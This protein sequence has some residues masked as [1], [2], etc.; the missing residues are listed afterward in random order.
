MEH[1]FTNSHLREHLHLALKNV[2]TVQ[3]ENEAD[4]SEKRRRKKKSSK[5]TEQVGIHFDDNNN[6]YSYINNNNNI[7]ALNSQILG[8]RSFRP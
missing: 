4:D 5:R 6:K 7:K 1:H 2:Q 3:I 8:A